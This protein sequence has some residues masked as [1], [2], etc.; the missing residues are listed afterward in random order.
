MGSFLSYSRYDSDFVDI[1]H[2]LLIS[3]GY[4]AWLDRRNISASSRWDREIEQAIKQR[5]HITVILSPD[6]VKSQNVADEWS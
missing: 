5:S 6:S 4:D 2:R 1:L 3:K